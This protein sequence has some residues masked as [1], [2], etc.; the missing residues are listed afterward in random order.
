MNGYLINKVA[1]RA[2]KCFAHRKIDFV[3]DLIYCI[4]G[5]CDLDLERLLNADE[6]NFRHDIIGIH[7]H[8]NR[9]TKQ[10]DNY[11]YPRFAK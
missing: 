5:G 2:N 7:K 4:E 11:F 3:M 1:E 8:L 10:L 9:K 6:F